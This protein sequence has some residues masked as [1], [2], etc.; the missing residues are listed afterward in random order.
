MN[1][2]DKQAD[3][4]QDVVKTLQN[5]GFRAISD[6]RNEKIGFKIRERTLQKVPFLLVVGDKEVE[7]GCVAVRT[8]T[9]EDLG[10]MSIEAFTNFLTKDVDQKGYE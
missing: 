1:I 3:Y 2:P 5:N 9:G 6:F 10:S 4:C 8:R 7:T